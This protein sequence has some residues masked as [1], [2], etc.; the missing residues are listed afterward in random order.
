MG[1]ENKFP[2]TRWEMWGRGI[3]QKLR[4]NTY[5]PLYIKQIIKKDLLYIAQGSLLN[6]L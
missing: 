1:I 6:I 2:V 3:N 5:T 4:M